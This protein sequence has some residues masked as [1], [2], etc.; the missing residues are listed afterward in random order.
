MAHN[1]ITIQG[2]LRSLAAS[3]E[4]PL[5]LLDSSLFDRHLKG[6]NEELHNRAKALCTP[7]PKNGIRLRELET[8]DAGMPLAFTGGFIY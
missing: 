5:N 6:L 1:S 8:E 7:D 2:F 4:Y 3:S